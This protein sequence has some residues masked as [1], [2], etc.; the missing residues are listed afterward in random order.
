MLIR[1]SGVGHM[2]GFD[3]LRADKD[4]GDQFSLCSIQ[5]RLRREDSYSGIGADHE[6]LGLFGQLSALC[7]TLIRSDFASSS[8]YQGLRLKG[9]LALTGIG[10]CS[11]IGPMGSGLVTDRSY[12]GRPV[13][14]GSDPFD[15][16]GPNTRCEDMTR[17]ASLIQV[18]P[19]D[20]FTSERSSRRKIR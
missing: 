2:D 12:S 1:G 19:W 8:L 16:S 17:S 11:Q 20:K 5:A 7:V 3:F 13:G 9:S 14:P 18:R 4:R 6:L 15:C 10:P